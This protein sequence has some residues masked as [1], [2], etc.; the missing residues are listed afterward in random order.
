[1]RYHGGT[2]GEFLDTFEGQIGVNLG[3]Y[4]PHSPV[5]RW[6]MGE[7]ASHRAA[8]ADE[9]TA[10]QAIVRGAMRD[11]AI[12][13]ST[14]QLDIHVAHD[15]REVP[16]NYAT[17]A[18]LV[19]LAGALRAFDH[20]ALEFIPRSFAEGLNEADRTLLCDMVRA[21]GGKPLEIQTLTPM[22]HQPDAWL[23]TLDFCRDAQRQ[24]LPIHPMFATNELG[25]HLSLDSTFLFDEIPSFRETLILPHAERLQRL[26]DPALRERL[27]RELADP[28][29]RAF[30]FAWFVM[31]VETVRDPA[32]Q[33]Y[34]GK[35]V[36]ELADAA[37]QDP[38]DWFLDTSLAENL[39]TQFVLSM[40]R[41]WDYR[42]M[43]ADIVR[44]PIVM[45]GSSDGGAHLLSFT[46]AD[47]TTRLLSEWVPTIL[48]LE[49]AVA[50]LTAAGARVHGLRDR[51][52]LQPGVWADVTIY[53]PHRLRV[54]KTRLARD[55]PGDSAR[56]VVD[57]EGYVATIV[58][59]QVLMDQGRHTGAL[60]GHVLRGG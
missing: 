7:D 29:G 33:A 51:G 11:G 26:R 18:E 48:T 58:N 13:F 12:G 9:I 34:V 49:Q 56:Y 60:P 14:S 44:D 21:A 42:S 19:A 2:F 45:A 55:F 40:P 30:M 17:A 4:V 53:D 52:T 59:G 23:R 16:S 39:E 3:T 28:T 10:M 38:L 24:G 43:A 25:A 54:G 37:G 35:H 36:Q 32:H 22:P 5:R 46:G 1:V 41:E 20:G 8:T 15:G 50:R 27:R 31:F 47:Y 57:A 6:V